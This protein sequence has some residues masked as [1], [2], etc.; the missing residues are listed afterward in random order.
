MP[1]STSSRDTYERLYRLWDRLPDL[2]NLHGINPPWRPEH[3]D[4]LWQQ[5]VP[6]NCARGLGQLEECAKLYRDIQDGDERRSE[7]LWAWLQVV[8][9][10]G[11]PP[12]CQAAY[13]YLQREATSRNAFF[14]S[15]ELLNTADWVHTSAAIRPD[16]PPEQ[17]GDPDDGLPEGQPPGAPAPVLQGPAGE[18][19]AAVQP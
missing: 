2:K 12:H 6:P 16:G 13:R 15:S 10:G 11:L 1:H 4:L 17:P 8:D 9:P 14:E 3:F 7:E 19:G 18:S 5:H